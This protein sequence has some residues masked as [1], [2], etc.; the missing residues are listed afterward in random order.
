[1][2]P[3]EF[4]MLSVSSLLGLLKSAVKVN[5]RSRKSSARKAEM[6]KVTSIEGLD[7]RALLS[8]GDLLISEYLAN[9][10]GTDARLEYVELVATRAIDFSVTPYSVVWTNNGT[11]TSAGWMAGGSTTYGFAITAGSVNPGDVVYVGGDQMAPTGTKLRVINTASTAGDGFGNPSSSGNLGNGGAN[12]DSIG[13]FDVAVGSIT[14]STVPIDAVF[15]GTGAGTALVSSGSAGY[16]LPLNDRYSGGKLQSTSFLAPDPASGEVTIAT[17]EYNP[18]TNTFPVARTFANGTTATNGTTAIT[19]TAGDNVAPTI[20]DLSPADNAVDVP[21]ASNLV[22]TFSETVVTGS[23]DILI[24]KVSNGSTVQS[25]AVASVAISGA[26]ATIDPPAD[27]AGSDDF[28]IEIPNTAFK[29]VAGNF[30]AGISLAT[31]WNFQTAAGADNTAPLISTLSPANVAT[32]VAL[33]A[34]LVATFDE[35]IQKGAGN[36]VIKKVSDNSVVQT[37]D[38]ASSDVT[39]SGATA[40]IDPPADLLNSIQYYVE[41]DSTAFQDL[42]GNAFAGITGSAT[43]SFTT[44]DDL[45]PPTVVTIDDGDADNAVVTDVVLTYTITFSEDIDA[46]S[47]TEADFDNA[48]T[49]AITIGTITETTPRVFT[50]QVTPTTAGTLILRIPTGSVI[51]DTAGNSLTV[52]VLDDDTLT[53]TTPDVTPPTVSSIVDDRSGAAISANLPVVYTITFSE[54]INA[55]TVSAVDFSNAGTSS[56]LI[57]AIAEPSPGVFTVT[58]TPTTPGTLT[59]QIASTAV[60]EDTSGNLLVPPVTDDTTITVNAVTTLS[61][62]DIAFTGIQSDAPDTFSFVLLKDVVFGTSITFTDNGWGDNGFANT[63]EQTATVTFGSDYPAGTHLVVSDASGPDTFFLV[64][65][66]TSAG[67]IVGSLNG[68]SASGDSV[69]AYQGAVPTSNT[70]TNW[71]AGIS[72]RSFAANPSGT[73]ESNLPSALTI[74][75]TA[76]QL[77]DTTTETDNGFYNKP[78]F[79][80][81]IADIRASVNNIENWTKSDTDLT[82]ASTKFTVGAVT[83][84][85][86]INEVVFNPFNSSDTGEEYIELRGT[87]NAYLQ[88]NTYLVFLDGDFEDNNG[89]INH[90][91]FVGGMQFGSNGFLVLLQAGSTYSVDPAATTVTASGSGWGT[92]FSSTATDIENG[93]ESV[94]I[95]STN[96]A[97]V[98]DTDVDADNDAVLDGA[99]TAVA[100]AWTV[101]DALGNIDGGANDTAYG[102]FNTTG[103]TTGAG[104]VPPGSTFI[105]IPTLPAPANKAYHPD[106]MA[107]NGNSTGNALSDWVFGELAGLMPNASLATGGFAYPTAYEGAALN[108]IGAV[109]NFTAGNQAPTNI[110]LSGATLAENAGT[111]AV[112]GTFSAEDPDTGDTF[113]FSLPSDLNDNSRFNVNGTSLRANASFDFEAGSTYTITARVTDAGGLTFDRQFTISITDVNEAI[114]DSNIFYNTNAAAEKTFSPDATGQRSMIQNVQIV[115]SGNLTVLAGAVTNGGFVLTKLG[116]T[117]TNVGLRVDSSGFNALSGKTTIVL[118]FTSGTLAAGSL[119]DG[120]YRLLIDYGVLNIDGDSDGRAGGTKTINF[121]RLFGDSDGDRDVDARDY[122]NYVAGVRGVTKW[123]SIFDSDN[124][125]SLRVGSL[126]DNDDKIAFFANFGRGI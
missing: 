98:Q 40:T 65:T 107:R 15:F 119:A 55:S 16:Q 25:I 108:H 123:T 7:T 39:V 32:N 111:N 33:N 104:T 47:V 124:D 100:T 113:S 8:A 12:A 62:G 43:W 1:M 106:Y 4:V 11:A 120:T 72:T 67:T 99:A 122:S 14:N 121:H 5:R 9:P 26:V 86:Y 89:N 84:E 116:T 71:I 3:G 82:K 63:S 92:E 22:V 74:G 125:G 6:R 59:L 34:N 53:V 76:I 115:F 70:A 79:V 78:A 50:V 57:G 118:D 35:N 64:G 13:V 20:L 69:L 17:G 102:F 24:K 96:T 85:W 77:S 88:T 54:D 87:P 101:R 83:T 105:T 36:I 21:V 114:F 42:S 23:G 52:P 44:L 73:N 90:I 27:L 93:S 38:V 58:V 94:L 81:T 97:P 37:I 80:G 68:I 61:A 48:G 41:I 56:I 46:A 91:F 66:T 2:S 112:I 95:I 103:S 117:G 126:Q 49:S 31:T 51:T 109:N 18:S 10:A 28:Y 45:I 110:I 19:L 30:F 29:D 60:I 75:V